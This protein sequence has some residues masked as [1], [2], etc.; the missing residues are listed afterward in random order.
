MNSTDKIYFMYGLEIDK[1]TYIKLI[2]NDFDLPTHELILIDKYKEDNTTNIDTFIK[3]YDGSEICL[4]TDTEP[5]VEM[6]IGII[7]DNDIN[8]KV[9]KEK[10]YIARGLNYG[11][12]F[13]SHNYD[14]YAMNDIMIYADIN[15]IRTALE[16]VSDEQPQFMVMYGLI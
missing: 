11:I 10:Y 16:L 12:E 9:F 13:G 4:S 15:L 3:D 5:C 8:N 6:N 14:E 7:P 1:Q 2:E